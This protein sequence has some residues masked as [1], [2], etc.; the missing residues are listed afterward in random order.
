MV[1]NGGGVAYIYIYILVYVFL[2]TYRRLSRESLSA[3]RGPFVGRA[4]CMLS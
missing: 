2:I 1:D 4:V 3:L